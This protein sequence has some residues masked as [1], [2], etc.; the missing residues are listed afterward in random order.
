VVPCGC[1]VKS[2]MAPVRFRP[3]LQ[4]LLP[5]FL[6]RRSSRREPHAI[7]HEICIPS[8]RKDFARSLGFAHIENRQ[9]E[10]SMP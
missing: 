3:R 10:P 6:Q 8:V 4:A 7:S 5:Q 2:S 9:A 1:W